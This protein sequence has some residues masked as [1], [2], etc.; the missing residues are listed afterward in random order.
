[1][2]HGN[3]VT[4]MNSR[5]VTVKVTVRVSTPPYSLA[6]LIKNKKFSRTVK[7]SVQI[8]RVFLTL[9]EMFFSHLSSHRFRVASVA[10]C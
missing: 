9:D 4:G 3:N 1:M 5:H 8:L 6:F 7:L 2:G 10:K